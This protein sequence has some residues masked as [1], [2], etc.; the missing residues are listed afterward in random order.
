[1]VM[2]VVVT[3]QVADGVPATYSPHVELGA[4]LDLKAA[5]GIEVRG[6]PYVDHGLLLLH[7]VMVAAIVMAFLDRS[8]DSPALSSRSMVVVEAL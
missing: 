3:Q 8:M 2:V 6:A 1:M 4:T 7:C 5:A